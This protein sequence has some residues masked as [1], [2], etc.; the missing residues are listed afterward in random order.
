[1]KPQRFFGYGSLV[2]GATHSFKIYP[3]RLRGWTRAWRKCQS[4]NRIILSVEPCAGT[5]ISG[6][7]AEVSSEEG[8]ASLKRREAAYDLKRLDMSQLETDS[9]A[10]QALY[11]YTAKL[12]AVN[13]A[14]SD[15]PVPLSYLDCVIQ[16]FKK[17]HG[18]LGADEFFTTTSGW[19]IPIVNDR[20]APIYPRHVALDS[21]E[22]RYVDR[23]LME[24]PARIMNP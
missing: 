16:G 15:N 24:L 1:M 19:E 10:Q 5:E 8:L 18:E 20:D 17:I 6:V 3:A 4:F 14:F 21:A 13:P 23:K 22:R 2:N 7:I 9:P 11:V 12:P